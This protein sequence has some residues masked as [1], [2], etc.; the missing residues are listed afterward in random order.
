MAGIELEA[1][2]ADMLPLKAML[3]DPEP[4]TALGGDAAGRTDRADAVPP[5]TPAPGP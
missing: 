4:V 2:A 5:R 3:P 1:P